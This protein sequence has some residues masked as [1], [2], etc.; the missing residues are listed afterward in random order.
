MLGWLTGPDPRQVGTEPDA[1]F[2]WA[3][4][5]TLLAW[6]RT[7]LALVSVGLAITQ[8]LPPFDF[9]G[10]R[11]VVGLPLIAL[12]IVVSLVSLREWAANERA[13][14]TGTPLPRSVLPRLL[15]VT[16]ALIGVAALL[17]SVIGGEP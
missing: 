13:L 12:G 5:R 16:I 7:A 1:R 15:A 9:A 17:V 10:G 14:R 2:S 11:H 3:N 8:L 6:N 4:E